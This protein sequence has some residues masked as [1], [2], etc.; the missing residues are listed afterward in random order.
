LSIR[1]NLGRQERNQKQ[2]R[3]EEKNADE[4]RI[5]VLN[6]ETVK[7]KNKGRPKASMPKPDVTKDKDRV[8]SLA[9]ALRNH[10][11]EKLWD[12]ECGPGRTL[13]I[14]AC[15]VMYVLCKGGRKT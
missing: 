4:K 15:T 9:F 12:N 1:N 13:G 7:K 14:G 8:G 11:R 10:N 3:G 5:F 6:A 2:T